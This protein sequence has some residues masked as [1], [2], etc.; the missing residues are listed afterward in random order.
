MRTRV[1]V[2]ALTALCACDTAVTAGP[3][4]LQPVNATLEHE[5]TSILSMRELRDGRVLI[6]DEGDNRLVVANVSTGQVAGV[7]AVG[8]GPGEFEGV[9]RLLSLPADSTLLV[10]Q[11]NGARWLLLVGT[12]IVATISPPDSALQIAGANLSGAAEYGE[13]LT[14]RYSRGATLPS[15]V[16]QGE[17]TA[18]RVRRAS[19]E[20]DTVTQMRSRD[21]QLR[22]SGPPANPTRIMFQVVYSDPEPALMFGDGWVAVAR[23]APYRVEWYP[24]KQAP[25]LG[26]PIPWTAPKVTEAE[27]Q[28]W[29]SRAVAR[30]G[31]PLAFGANVVPFADEVPPFR[32]NGLFATPEGTLLIAK[33]RW[34][35]SIGTEYDLVDRRGVLVSTLR[36][37]E[38]E[39]VVGFGRKS[40]YTAVRDADDIERLQ[41]HPW[42]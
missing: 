12:Q 25:I 4:A 1:A 14:L 42:P 17:A 8:A 10:D 11:G 3:R 16:I 29:E 20:T 23:R 36:L 2:T 22:E 41:R 19:G 24:P 39:R 38:S 7:G 35:G 32:E 30:L 13:V 6:A 5:F 9:G 31:K 18:L 26:A 28:A 15:G 37:P 27:K 33:A 40:V 34:S 21:M